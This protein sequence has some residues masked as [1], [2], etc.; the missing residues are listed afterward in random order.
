MS[1]KGGERIKSVPVGIK[2]TYGVA[3][4]ALGVEPNTTVETAFPFKLGSMPT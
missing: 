4:S 1:P 2:Y 3:L